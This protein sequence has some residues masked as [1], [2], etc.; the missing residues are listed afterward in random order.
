[1]KTA[2]TKGLTLDSKN[3]IKLSFHA[4]GLLRER[5]VLLLKEY[6]ETA[7]KD[8]YSKE[9]YSSPN[10]AYV[11]ADIAGY[12]RAMHEIISLIE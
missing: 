2:W 12:K 8:S 9:G 4:S 3:E 10:W 5:L 6:I 1:M 11:Q 7:D